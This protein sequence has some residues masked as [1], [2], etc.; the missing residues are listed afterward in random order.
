M[1]ICGGV[2]ALTLYS[3]LTSSL[4]RDEELVLQTGHFTFEKTAPGTL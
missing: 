2:E 1:K 3:F 4:G